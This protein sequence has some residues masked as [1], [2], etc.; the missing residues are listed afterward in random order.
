MGSTI[1]I[2]IIAILVFDYLLERLLEYLNSTL[3]SNKL[4]DE[5]KGIYDADKYCKAQEYA[6]VN[7][8]FSIFVNSL[9]LC[10]ILL[11]LFFD[12]FAFIDE[13][14]REYTTHSI[15]LA[16][17]FFGSLAFISDLLTTPLEIYKTFV[18]E[19]KFGFNKTTT[20]TFILDKFKSWILDAIL[21]GGILSLI[22]WIYES[23]GEYFWLLAWA[24]ISVVMIFMNMFYSSII[25]PIFNKQKPLEKGELRDE[26][27]KFAMKTNFQLDNIFV[28]DGS[29]RSNKANAYFSG[30]GSKKRI[31]LYD[32]LIENHSIQELVAILAHEIGHY[33]KKHTL[34]TLIITILQTGL[35]LFILSLFI[36]EEVLC[37]A[38]G[39]ENQSFHISLL[40]FGLLYSPLSIILGLIMNY[41]SRKNEYEADLF[42]GE[43]FDANAL[44]DGLKKLSVNNLSNL[45]PHPVFVFF[46][47]SHP[48]IL[49]RL[50][51]L[52]KIIEK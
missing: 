40:A 41:I 13:F 16:I 1:F 11:M 44:S 43:N 37:Y 4:P 17:C 3:W 2:I 32:T 12:G 26:I 6:R 25:V 14:F 35:M 20:K 42:A 50:K 51:A 28:I 22:I 39:M 8:K 9:S 18:I 49:K 33:K 23:G 15:L 5:L 36:K 29:K 52:K 48:P 45:K 30:L 21:G 7:R 19:E 31:V 46:H 27:E 24:C 47:Y 34:T 10:T 38:L